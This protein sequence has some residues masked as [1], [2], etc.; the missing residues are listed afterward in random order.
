M[1]PPSAGAC[2][3]G[4]CSTCCE[5]ACI[6]GGTPPY[7]GGCMRGGG[8]PISGGGGGIAAPG[9][10]PYSGRCCAA[11]GGGWDCGGAARSGALP[12]V[13]PGGCAGDAQW[14]RQRDA[15]KTQPG[16]AARQ[17]A[18]THRK[19]WVC[20]AQATS[21]GSHRPRNG[22]S[23]RRRRCDR[24]RRHGWWRLRERP[25]RPD[26]W[27]S[28]R[29][30]TD[31]RRGRRLRRRP[32][33]GRTRRDP[34]TRQAALA[35][36]RPNLR[37]PTGRVTAKT[38]SCGSECGTAAAHRVAAHQEAH[39]AAAHAARRAAALQAAAGEAVAAQRQEALQTLRQE[40]VAAVALRAGRPAAAAAAWPTVL[41]V[42]GT[43]CA[44]GDVTFEHAA[45]ER[46]RPAGTSC[47]TCKQGST[48]HD[49]RAHERRNTGCHVVRY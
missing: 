9:G 5:G 44:Q 48:Q 7:T 38:L 25:R 34:C 30:C 6:G 32:R 29:R 4:A 11:S 12:N 41:G 14:R 35:R 24:L 40:A 2:S 23:W 39:Q 16:S 27:R 19:H 49:K 10:A 46:T 47:A 45:R 1:D 8:T 21:R 13:A 36:Q 31:E 37:A 33:G 3:G 22:S 42:A 28:T 43:D 15:L 20:S 17:H 26:R 18:R